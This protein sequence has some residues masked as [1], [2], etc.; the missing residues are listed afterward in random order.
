MNNKVKTYIIGGATC[1][2][3]SALAMAL[4]HRVKGTI[5]CGDSLQLYKDIPL[6]TAQPSAADKS[7]I[8]HKMYGV[9]PARE[10]GNLA[11]WLYNATRTIQDVHKEGRVPIIVGGTGMY[12]RALDEGVASVPKISPE[13]REDARQLYE[14]EGVSVLYSKLQEED[15]EIAEK[16]NPN[17]SQRILRAYEVIKGTGR[18]LLYWQQHHDLDAVSQLENHWTVVLPPKA[19]LEPFLKKRLQGMIDEGALEE[20]K[21]LLQYGLKT[22]STV[23]RAIGVKELAAYLQGEMDLPIAIESATIATRQYVKRQHTWF[24]KYTPTGSYIIDEIMTADKARLYAEKIE[25]FFS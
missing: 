9:L 21:M 5:I 7:S 17:D 14:K 19:L 24:K 8:P 12:L 1:S 20:V 23:F 15:P 18:S 2:G 4:A 6:L 22:D 3:K 16:L 13:V 10:Q 11:K 25:Q